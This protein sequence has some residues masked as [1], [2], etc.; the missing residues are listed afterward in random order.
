MARLPALVFFM[1]FYGFQWGFEVFDGGLWSIKGFMAFKVA[2]DCMD[3][4][5]F[6]WAIIGI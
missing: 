2:I 5:W 3:F 6:S 4:Y 1:G